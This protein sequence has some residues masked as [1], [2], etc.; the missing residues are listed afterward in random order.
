MSEIFVDNFD[1]NGFGLPE[2]LP[3]E[4]TYNNEYVVPII[5]WRTWTMALIIGYLIL[6]NIEHAVDLSKWSKADLLLMVAIGIWA[7]RYYV[8][9]IGVGE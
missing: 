1:D 7:Y 6:K 4:E 8:L 5:N 2:D 9:N 3:E